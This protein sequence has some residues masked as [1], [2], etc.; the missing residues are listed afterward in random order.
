MFLEDGHFPSSVA[1]S[2]PRAESPALIDALVAFHMRRLTESIASSPTDIA[3][4]KHHCYLRAI[5]LAVLE[6]VRPNKY[7]A[8]DYILYRKQLI[9]ERKRIAFSANRDVEGVPPG[10]LRR[11]LRMLGKRHRWTVSTGRRQVL[12]QILACRSRS[13]LMLTLWSWQS[14]SL[15]LSAVL[16]FALR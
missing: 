8:D 5:S 14:I 7:T 3:K 2:I 9:D 15:L 11:V 6:D 10:G 16:R 4:S 1:N 12:A 13:A